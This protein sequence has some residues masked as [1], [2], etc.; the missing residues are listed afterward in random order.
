MEAAHKVYQNDDVF[1]SVVQHCQ[2]STLVKL[3]MVEQKGS[4]FDECVK[5]LYREVDYA[6][7][8]DFLRDTVSVVC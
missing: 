2:K 3:M 7:I 6:V 8:K 1:R 5:G 4:V